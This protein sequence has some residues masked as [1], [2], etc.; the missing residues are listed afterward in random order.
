MVTRDNYLAGIVSER[1]Y[2]RKVLLKNKSSRDTKIQEIMTKDV[3]CVEASTTVDTCVSLMNQRKI[4]HLPVLNGD[5][6]VGM[7]SVDDVLKFTIK[8]QKIVIA[9]LESYIMEES[10]GE[11]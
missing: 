10:G 1:D 11:G 3:I 8:D 9:E 4:R 6:P 7:I 5:T 2:A